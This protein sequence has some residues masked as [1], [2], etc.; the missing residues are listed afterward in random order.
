MTT[1]MSAGGLRHY[2]AH[3]KNALALAL[4]LTTLAAA[5]DDLQQR[6]G[7]IAAKAPATVGVAALDLELGR[8]V[9]VRGDERFPLGSVFK[10]P[11]ALAFLHR[12]DAGE[13]SLESSIT[14]RTQD[15]SVGFSPIRDNAR[16]QPINMT[17]GAILG[18]MLRDSDNTAVDVLLP[19]VG[20]A[21][22]VTQHLRSFGVAGIRID[23]SEREMAA[24]LAQPGGVA[25]YAADP[26]D[27]ATPR[28]ALELLRQFH[29]GKDRL[30]P[31]SHALAEKLM[32]ETTTGANRIKARL[33]PGTIVA[34][35]TGT[36]PGT[37]NDIAI[38][39]SADGKRHILMAIFT[40]AA[41]AAELDGR[42]RAIAQ[43]ARTICDD[44]WQRP[45]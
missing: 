32:I 4:T 24:D 30:S 26:R 39:T 38:V 36:M 13:F 28:E 11:V 20:G 5:P 42:E 34:H 1:A 17:Y 7:A 15:F 21:H 44:F 3:M 10:F 40:K 23:R 12:V 8:Q 35:K 16:G 45:P 9:A 18:A 37:A 31:T 29:L 14:I 25:R 43:I 6:I 19:R 41:T 27:T 22:G 2:Q 33:P